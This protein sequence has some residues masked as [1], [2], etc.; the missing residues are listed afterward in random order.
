[1]CRKHGGDHESCRIEFTNPRDKK[2]QVLDAC[3][4][5][6]LRSFVNRNEL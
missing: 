1:M 5:D 6:M 4:K 3:G 2:L